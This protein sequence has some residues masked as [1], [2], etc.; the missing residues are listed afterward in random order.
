MGETGPERPDLTDFSALSRGVGRIRS[1]T[2][3]AWRVFTRKNF[4]ARGV[5][6]L[7]S[8]DPV[9]LLALVAHCEFWRAAIR[10]RCR[11]R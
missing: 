10:L 2:E 8:R 11:D 3:L 1:E 9:R 5:P 6:E 4:H 7:R